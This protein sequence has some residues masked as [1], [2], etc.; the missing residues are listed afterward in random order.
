VIEVDFQE[1]FLDIFE[2]KMTI[3]HNG[4]ILLQL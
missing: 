3:L 1:V 4:S 2:S